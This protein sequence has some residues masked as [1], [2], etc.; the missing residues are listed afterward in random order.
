[1]GYHV[2]MRIAVALLL[3][4]SSL[5]ADHRVFELGFNPE[6]KTEIAR[7]LL[8]DEGKLYNIRPGAIFVIDTPQVLEAIA[9]V[10]QD[11]NLEKVEQVHIR[12]R[13]RGVGHSKEREHDISIGIQDK[14]V[15]LGVR[16]DNENTQTKDKR[17][18][19]VSTMNE[20][21][22]K[23][24]LTRDEDRLVIWRRLFLPHL[25]RVTQ[26]AEVLDVLPT[27]S[28]N[29]VMLELRMLYVVK[30]DGKTRT[31][32]TGSLGSKVVAPL[33]QWFPVGGHSSGSSS[34]TRGLFGLSEKKQETSSNEDWEVYVTRQ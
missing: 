18:L 33:G 29:R 5:W 3:F 23:L 34:R 2:T 12:L 19:Q 1:M 24:E 16:F 25:E 21:R 15:K 6:A 27:L 7:D 11:K 13:R 20:H 28:G 22:A 14:D 30:V 32:Q 10:I 9:A 26:E 8:S 17:V 4:L 31:F